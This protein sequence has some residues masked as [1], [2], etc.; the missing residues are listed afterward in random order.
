MLIITGET[1]MLFTIFGRQSCP[2]C[3][4]A[5]KKAKRLSEKVDGCRYRYVDIEKEGITKE[6]LEK[7]IGQPVATVPQIFIDEKYIGGCDDFEKWIEKKA[8]LTSKII[9]D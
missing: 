3:V 8:Y 6:A 9:S 4:R 7:T 1:I 5:K 2:Y